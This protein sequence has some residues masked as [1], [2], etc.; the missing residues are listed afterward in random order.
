[1]VWSGAKRRDR[2]KE[3]ERAT[4]KKMLPRRARDPAAGVLTI[5]PA[6]LLL[7][8]AAAMAMAAAEEALPMPMEVYFTPAELARIAGYGEEPVSSVSVSGQLTCELCLRPGSQLLALD[9]PGAKVAVTCKSDRTPS[10]QLDSFAFATTDEYGNFTID[11]PPQL[12][13]T[14][15]LEKAC[16]VKVLQLPADSCRLRHRTGDTYGLRLSSVEDGVRAYT[17]GVIRLQDSDTPSD[18]CVGVEHMSE[19]R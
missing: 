5:L 3:R 9:M 18:H 14:P 2:Q 10:N 1:M 12:H 19:R 15:D 8:V 11:L 6:I 7:A 13:A 17:A 4:A 16:T